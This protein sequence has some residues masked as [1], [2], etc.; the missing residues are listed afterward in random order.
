MIHI[1]RVLHYVWLGTRPMRPLMVEWQKK[2]AGLHPGW[3]VKTWRQVE[4]LPPHLLACEDELV[5]CRCPAYL[6][7]CP[8]HAKQSDVWRYDI[9]EQQGG[10]YLD[11]DF[12]PVKNIETLIEES[13]VKPD[14]SAVRETSREGL[15]TL[16]GFPSQPV[17][18]FAGLC[19][20]FYH[21]DDPSTANVPALEVG[22]SI[23][24]ATAHHPWLRELC[25]R[26]PCQDPTAAILAGLPLL[27]GGHGQAP[28]RAAARPRGL[29]PRDL[30][31]LR[32]E[33]LRGKTQPALSESTYAIHR[34]SSTWPEE[35]PA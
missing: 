9:L 4:G 23:M 18:A 20:T 8:T 29:L 10:V 31:P 1:P 5:E 11:A 13:R 7:S 14:G 19:Q 2:W 3:Q 27:D 17:E 32:P 16:P 6:A 28:R 33:D 15:E 30:G 25:S 34:W 22:C 21:W 26:T 35:I 24:G 12:E